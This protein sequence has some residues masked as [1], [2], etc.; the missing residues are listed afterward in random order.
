MNGY[1]AY[2][3]GKEIEVFAETSYKAQQQAVIVFKAKKSY[4]VTVMLCEKDTD[5]SKPGEQVTHTATE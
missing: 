3:R 2:Y 5:G 4:E 1:K